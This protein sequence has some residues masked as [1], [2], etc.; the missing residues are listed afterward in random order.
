M[1]NGHYVTTDEIIDENWDYINLQAS[2]SY[3]F[4]SGISATY[5]YKNSFS[6][7]LFLDYDYTSKTYTA[8][9]SPL[10]FLKDYA[11][12]VL[13]QFDSHEFAPSRR[14]ASSIDKQLHQW[15]LGGALCVSF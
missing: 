7:R 3:K 13:E 8:F 2:N 12:Q 6:W 9:Y 1:V 4:G 10:A 14:Y 11:P 5:A 15:V